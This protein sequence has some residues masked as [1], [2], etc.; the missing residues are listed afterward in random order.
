MTSVGFHVVSDS[1]DQLIVLQHD[2]H[3]RIARTST[4]ISRI[5]S[6]QHDIRCGVNHRIICWLITMAP[7]YLSFF[8]K[9][10]PPI[11]K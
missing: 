9:Y 4:P 8:M 10:Y 5:K 6:E 2:G 3:R 7:L 1:R 11:T